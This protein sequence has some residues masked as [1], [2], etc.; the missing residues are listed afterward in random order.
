MDRG[1]WRAMVHGV[2]KSQAWM[3]DWMCACTHAGT[4]TPFLLSL[5]FLWRTVLIMWSPGS[6]PSYYADQ[7]LLSWSAHQILFSFAHS[8]ASMWVGWFISLLVSW[9]SRL[10]GGRQVKLQ[11]TC[12]HWVDCW[13]V[14]W[15]VV[16]LTVSWAVS[17]LMYQP[18]H[19]LY[20]TGFS[21]LSAWGSGT[22]L[23]CWLTSSSA[24]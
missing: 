17:L 19:W 2:V 18:L 6:G 23:A 24:S 1:A 7:W 16:P 12:S 22:P 13:S 10:W 11:S 9:L 3:S 8:S 21:H 14:D 15:S 5:I 20:V 4:H